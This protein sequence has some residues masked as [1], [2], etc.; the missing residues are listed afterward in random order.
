M[1]HYA[2]VSRRLCASIDSRDGILS[3]LSMVVA[4]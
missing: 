2:I 3:L 1:F 4:I